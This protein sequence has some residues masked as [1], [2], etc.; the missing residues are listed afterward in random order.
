[1]RRPGRAPW[2]KSFFILLSCFSFANLGVGLGEAWLK[3][4]LAA[5]VG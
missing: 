1:M 2:V 3:S 4:G 5:F